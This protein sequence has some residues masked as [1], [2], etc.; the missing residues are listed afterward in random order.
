[1]IQRNILFLLLFTFCSIQN[2]IGQNIRV[3][4]YLQDATPHSL[5]ILWETDSLSESIVEWG[6]TEVLGNTNMGTAQNSMGEAMIHEVQLEGLTP[7][8]KY[9]Y[10]VKTENATSEI[11]SFKTPPLASSDESFRVIAM[12]DMQRDGSFP[13]KFQEIVEQGIIDYLDEE[14]GGELIDNLALVMIPG[15]LV[16][17]GNTHNSWQEMFFTPSQNL[18]TQVPVYPVPGN[19]EKNSD[20]FFQYFKMPDNGTIGFEEHW[21]HKDYGNVRIIGLDSNAS[22]NVPEQLDWLELLLTETCT[23]DSI[24]FVFAQLHHPHKSELWTPG[25]SDYT[26][27]VVELLEQF[28]TNC[29][30]PSLHFFGHTHAYARG[31]S[32]DHR[33]LWINSS[34]AGGAIDNWGEYASFDY[35]EFSLSQD[36]YG[37]V[38]VEV[39]DGEDPKIVIKRISRGDQDIIK[40][41]ELSDSMTLH[42]H[43]SVVETPI[44]ISPMDDTVHPECLILKAS[45][46]SSPNSNS[47]HGQSHWQVSD[48]LFGD[49]V[50]ESWKNFENWFFEIDT[51]LGDDLTDEQIGGLLEN[52][53]YWWRVRYRDRELNWSEWSEPVSFSTSSSLGSSNLILNPGAENHLSNWYLEAG[54]V[55]ILADGDCKGITPHSGINYFAVGGLCD[56]SPTATLVQDI[57]LSA[58]TDEID[59]GNYKVNFGGYFSNFSGQD[60]PEMH[61]SFLDQAG[62]ELGFSNTISSLNSSW[63]L[64]Q[65]EAIIPVQTL[66]IRVELKGTRNA[67]TDNDSY[68][69]DLFLTLGGKTIDCN[70]LNTFINQPLPISERLQM[71]PNPM[72]SKAS[73]RIPQ[74]QVLQ[75]NSSEIKLH[76]MDVNGTKVD[77]P[78][79]YG[80]NKIVIERGNLSKGTYFFSLR[81]QKQVIGQGKFIILE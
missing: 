19:H 25:E 65:E 64:V 13:D 2:S 75:T 34:S 53:E 6:P 69:D 4:P 76:I 39:T 1:M 44:P 16:V 32:R 63:T 28:S 54:V 7:F 61:L 38:S 67:G 11:Y 50:I 22:F 73:I 37:F 77:C 46:F 43:P 79:H 23:A 68:F 12:S 49:P 21:W 8:T 30:K 31:N 33:H 51:Q 29:G 52:T 57:N 58:Y 26:G 36:E 18:L 71:V 17:N 45:D 62:M 60:L 15:D 10:R 56:H 3:L 20:Y 41:N 27:E 48:E 24:D 59:A 81:N 42:L 80:A 9:F 47:L 14:F 74:N 35:D 40:D 5:Y 78:T 66:T 55:E 70:D 72:T